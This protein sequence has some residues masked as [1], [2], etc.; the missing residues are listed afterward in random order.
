MQSPLDAEALTTP[1]LMQTQHRDH[2]PRHRPALQHHASHSPT[3]W[4]ALRVDVDLVTAAGCC[5]AFRQERQTRRQTC[6]RRRRHRGRRE[7]RARGGRGASPLCSLHILGQ[8]HGPVPRRHGSRGRHPAAGPFRQAGDSTCA[9]GRGRHRA[10]DLPPSQ[11]RPPWISSRSART[12]AHAC[13]VRR[14]RRG[15]TRALPPIA[16]PWWT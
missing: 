8:Q 6:T 14:T 5:D 13:G 3:A 2:C 7:S 15:P 9:Q 4:P 1:T 10:S 11:Q 12:C 16:S